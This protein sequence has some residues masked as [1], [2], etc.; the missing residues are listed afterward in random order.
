MRG[1]QWQVLHLLEGLAKRGHTVRLLAAGGS[2]LFALARKRGIAVEAL[3][4]WL[5]TRSWDLVHAHDARSHTLAALATRRPLVVSRRVAFPV[6]GGIASR[7]KYRRAAH[8]IAISRH[9]AGKL[10][11]A[12]VDAAR[13]TVIYDGVPLESVPSSNERKLI[14]TPASQDPMKGH[15][16]AADA[17]RLAG[18]ALRASS[19]LQRVL[20]EAKLFLYLTYSEGLGSAVLLAMAT[21]VPVI[22]SNVGG[23]PEIVIDNH[24]GL[25]V[26]NQAEPVA[27]AIRRLCADS[28]LASRLA[29]E[30]RSLVQ[31]QFSVDAMVDQTVSVYRRV[32]G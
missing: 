25:L 2:P 12:G 7:W 30:A 5:S 4:A 17:C 23:L 15:A 19:D 31:R 16:L 21:G 27:A 28:E 11:E 18:V 6:G 8:Y 22:A 10:A 1:G 3:G 20:P 26:E 13:I 14:V 32:L 24:T 9:V 29:G